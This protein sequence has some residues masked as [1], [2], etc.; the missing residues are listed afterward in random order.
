MKKDYLVK[1]IAGALLITT[2]LNSCRDDFEFEEFD[3]SDDSIAFN[4]KVAAPLI[5]SKIK[6][7]DFKPETIN[8]R[9]HFSTDN[10]GLI[11]MI[12]D[13]EDKVQALP[14]MLTP[15]EMAALGL[16]P[17]PWQKQYT[18]EKQ[19]VYRDNEKGTLMIKNPSFTLNSKTMNGSKIDLQINEIQ[20][21]KE[22]GTLLKTVTPVNPEYA[23]SVTVDNSTTNGELSEALDMMPD[24]Y[25]MTYTAKS[26]ELKSNEKM[27]VNIVIDM[28]LEIKAK[29][30]SIAD[31]IELDIDD[32]L[33]NVDQLLLKSKAENSL[34]IDIK[35][36]AYF[37]GKETRIDLL[38]AEGPW[39]IGA[40]TTDD[41]G[42]VQK[43]VVVNHETTFEKNRIEG[44]LNNKCDKLVYEIELETVQD[45]YVKIT[46]IQNIFMRMS[47][48]AEAGYSTKD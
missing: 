3:K 17:Q 31:T 43:T 11:H 14:N 38:Y 22:D 6:F 10:T 2:A 34:P 23:E 12:I 18:T 47:M 16:V 46:D 39:E 4:G 45:K 9:L 48:C 44:L 19:D 7:S 33:E 37:I 28:P 30:F 15:E 32:I 35:F 13:Q 41:D 27:R 20:F 26:D 29:G 1:L 21:Y 8:K 40:A 24:Y 5:N 36:Q 42:K 25:I